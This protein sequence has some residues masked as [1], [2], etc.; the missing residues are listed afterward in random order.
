MIVYLLAWIAALTGGLILSLKA[1]DGWYVTVRAARR[2][3]LWL[4]WWS[5]VQ[6]ERARLRAL[7]RARRRLEPLP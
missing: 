7:A 3:R 5:D 1:V 2:F 4:S 6:R